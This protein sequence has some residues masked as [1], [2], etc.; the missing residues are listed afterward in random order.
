MLSESTPQLLPR[1]QRRFSMVFTLIHFQMTPCIDLLSRILSFT[2]KMNP[3]LVL[4]LKTEPS[5]PHYQLPLLQYQTPLLETQ[6]Q[7]SKP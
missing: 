2:Q 1:L 7:L 3:L 6:V 4:S 5:Q